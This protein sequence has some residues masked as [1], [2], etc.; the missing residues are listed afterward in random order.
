MRLT[1]K[2][3]AAAGQ[4]IPLVGVAAFGTITLPGGDDRLD[5]ARLEPHHGHF[6][7]VPGSKW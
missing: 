1:G 4:H 7:L 6:V 5:K 2:A 3:T